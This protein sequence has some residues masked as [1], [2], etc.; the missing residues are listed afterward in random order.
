MAS[1][2]QPFVPTYP[3]IGGFNAS[4]LA[5][6]ADLSTASG[7]LPTIIT[8]LDLDGKPDIFIGD[9]AAGKISIFRNISTNGSL[10]AGSFAPRVDLSMGSF[11]ASDPYSIAAGDVN[12]DGKIDIVAVNADNKVISIFRNASQP[13]NIDTNSFDTRIDVS[14]GNVMRGV[15]LGDLDG[16]GKIDIVASD[17]GDST[18]S[19][20]QNQCSGT[21][22]SFASRVSFG[23]AAGAFGV[24]IAD[25]DR[26]GKADIISVNNGGGSAGTVSIWKNISTTG[27]I[28][29][30]SFMQR[31]DLPAD[32]SG[33]SLAIADID[34]DGKLDLV[35]GSPS[36]G[37]IFIYRNTSTAGVINNNSFAPEV[38]FGAA[39]TVNHV[40]LADIDG[41]GKVDI[42]VVTQASG[43][44]SVFKNVS[45]P[46]NF[47]TS[48]LAPRVDFSASVNAGGVALGDLDGD[49]RPDVVFNNFY[50]NTM[51]IYRNV[52]PIG[53]LPA[54]TIQPTN[55]TVSVGGTANFSVGAIGTAPLSYQWQFNGSNNISLATNTILTITNVSLT[56]AGFYSVTVSNQFGSVTSSNVSLTVTGFDHFG[57]GSIPSPRFLNSPFAV[58]IVAQDTAN[59]TFTN[60]TGTVVISATNGV[61]VS[62]QLSGNFVAGV[63]NGAIAVPQTISG[64]TLK[65]NDAAGHFGF[66]NTI[67]IVSPP[68]LST[69]NFGTSLL[70]AWPLSPSGFVLESS[71]SLSPGT[72]S[73]VPGSPIPFNGQNLQS[74]PL[75]DTNQ[76][77]RLRFSGP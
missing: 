5:E 57:W 3:G 7:P 74:V 13:G 48:S 53:Q 49:G 55:L 62:P 65:A 46:G 52:I 60:F 25:V 20:F 10:S 75:S 58:T 14:G 29:D 63:W 72:W 22:I 68:G 27:L 39:G 18:V 38:T 8:D 64:L 9:A 71:S 76:F 77:F 34:G 67:D 2:G 50:D 47:T 4:S 23:T 73:I 35:V 1:T 43:V 12:G 37:G 45:T 61:L 56:N 42:A 51:S 24:G 15:V 40:A 32:N 36:A 59:A 66:A 31:I 44:L 11:G 17:T 33:E 26:D 69:L 19:V 28:S 6:R 54:I 41:D 21:N 70:V 30:T 16:D